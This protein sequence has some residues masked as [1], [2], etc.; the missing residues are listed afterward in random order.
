MNPKHAPKNGPLQS[1]R[2]CLE[3]SMVLRS[4]SWHSY[5]QEPATV[6]CLVAYRAMALFWFHL[7]ALRGFIA[8][9]SAA[10]HWL[11]SHSSLFV[12]LIFISLTRLSPK[13]SATSITHCQCCR[14]LCS[15]GSS[16][17]LSGRLRSLH[18][19][20]AMYSN[21][22]A[23]PNHALQRTAPCVTA[24]ASAAALPPTMQV[25]RRT[26]LSL[27]LRSLGRFARHE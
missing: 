11:S 23:T 26:P 14:F 17:G 27:S 2:L 21:P 12:Q 3:S 19:F 10:D 9:R 25:P 13:D 4:R 1:Q 24:P 8:G 22:T 20:F 7:R 15:R 5:A 16:F 18:L 6:G